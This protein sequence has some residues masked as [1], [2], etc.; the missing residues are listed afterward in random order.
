M[1]IH[2]PVDIGEET[3]MKPKILAR[4]AESVAGV[5]KYAF[6]T[7]SVFLVRPVRDVKY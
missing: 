4:R 3:A 5:E 7:R 1:S 2:G 6:M